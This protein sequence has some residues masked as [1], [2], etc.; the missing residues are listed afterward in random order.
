[1]N[2]RAYYLILLIPSVFGATGCHE[3]V[4]GHLANPGLDNR[5]IKTTLFF[6]GQARDGSVWYKCYAPP[7]LD[8]Y[9]VWPLDWVHLKWSES[10]ANRDFTLD[11]MIEA[12]VNIVT[13]SSWGESFFECNG[14]WSSWAPMQTAPA[15]H[16]ELFDAAVRKQL[17]IMPLIESR[18]DWHFRGEFPTGYDPAMNQWG[19]I[20]PGT[21]S[22]IVELINRYV[23]NPRHPEWQKR[24]AR[25]YNRNGEARY[26]ISII[27]VASDPL[28]P[29]DPQAHR[30]FAEGFDAIAQRVAEKTNGVKVGFFIDVLPS[31]TYAPGRFRPTPEE[32]GPELTNTDSILGIQCYL[33]E[34]W[35]GIEDI[36]QLIN[37]K[38]EFSRRWWLTGIPFL[39][40]VAPGY[41]NRIVFPNTPLAFGFNDR[42][43]NAQS[44]MVRAF[45]ENGL[46]YNFWNGYTEG[47]TA[48]PMQRLLDD[49]Y[50]CGATFYEWFK[51]LNP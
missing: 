10:D 9:S 8:K 28:D 4:R 37:W 3:G 27:Q 30:K 50:C 32:T 25:V 33:P 1:M 16:D 7:N 34:V 45:G 13:M 26:A 12:G 29:N 11:R 2:R 31:G 6:A 17:L 24:W 36:D 49:T 47:V 40:D 51:S 15:A 20:A 14:S 43:K 46:H 22:Q 44:D 38:W 48:V 19:V 42:W 18:D 41:D 39:M 23:S 5:R 21:V 35:L